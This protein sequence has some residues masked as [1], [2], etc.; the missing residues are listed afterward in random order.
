MFELIQW[1]SKLLLTC[2]AGAVQMQKGGVVIMRPSVNYVKPTMQRTEQE[3][4]AFIQTP[5]GKKL[6]A[7]HQKIIGIFKHIDGH[8]NRIP[9]GCPH[10]WKSILQEA[11]LAKRAEGHAIPRTP[12]MER[13]RKHFAIVALAS[14]AT[15]HESA[16]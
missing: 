7:E 5:E 3:W 1:I 9:P 2:T 6:A 8:E 13:K 16:H 11:C 12:L 14:M 4:E 10:W 15:R